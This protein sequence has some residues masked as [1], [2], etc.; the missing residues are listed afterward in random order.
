M[1]RVIQQT[2]DGSP[3]IVVPDLQLSYH[4]K[5]GALQESI[6]VFINAG[7]L[8]LFNTK[9]TIHIFEVGFG[10]GLNA[11][12]T[13]QQSIQKQQKIHYSTIE[14]FPLEALIYENL[15]YTILLND[16]S[17]QSY[18]IAMHNCKWEEQANI[19]TLFT[20]CKSKT[21]LSCFSTDQLFDLIY[22]D[23]FDPVVQPELW[24]QEIF[25]RLFSSLAPNGILVTYSSKGDVRRAMQA[26]GF[27]VEKL[28]G[29][30]KKREMIKAIK[31]A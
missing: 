25:E 30:A 21:S 27:L 5:H 9:E 1:Q 22:F 3:T 4:S 7:L 18:F 28:K 31:K 17:L 2:E 15:D 11:I 12:L 24:T 20:L 8:P 23:A 6:H 10:T 29:P 13:L 26:A 16:P 14:L 19:H